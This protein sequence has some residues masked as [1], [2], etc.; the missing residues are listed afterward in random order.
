MTSEEIRKNIC[1]NLITIRKKNKLTQQKFGEIFSYSDKTVSK[2]EINESTPSVDTLYKICEHFNIDIKSMITENI[3]EVDPVYTKSFLFLSKLQKI[4]I[5]FFFIALVTTTTLLIYFLSKEIF[6]TRIPFI[7]LWIIPISSYAGQI[8]L[9]K[10]F[11]NVILKII[12][13]TLSVWSTLIAIYYTFLYVNISFTP[14]FFLG[15]P[16]QLII[17]FINILNIWKFKHIQDLKSKNAAKTN[18]TQ[19]D[20][21]Q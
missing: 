2:W 15:L 19:S 14:L 12:F 13:E 10:T 4:I 3:D 20:T 1:S 6:S 8:F 7:F 17:I 21:T 18:N 5:F 11:D 9:K 16:L